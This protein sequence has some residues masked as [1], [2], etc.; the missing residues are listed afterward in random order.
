[1]YPLV[2]PKRNGLEDFD[3]IVSLRRVVTGALLN[4]KRTQI[5]E[6]YDDYLTHSGNGVLLCPI[7][8]TNDC[9]EAL[10]L[11]FDSLARGR[12]HDFLRDEILSSA[13]HDACPYCN[14][15]PVD[16]LGVCLRKNVLNDN[17]LHES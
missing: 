16:S 9:A 17:R 4:Q 13:L 5:S 12:S 6:A 14:A 2:L 15:T 11:N 3:S 7:N 10:K 8:I 1:M